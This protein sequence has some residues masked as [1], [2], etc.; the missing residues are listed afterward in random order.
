[1]E[2]DM[3]VKIMAEVWEHSQAKGSE[4]L[5]L[6]ALSHYADSV[7]AECWPSVRR[8]ALMIRMSERN[9]Q[10]LLRKL[11]KDGHIAITLRGST[12]KTNLYRILFPWCK[13]CTMHKCS[14]ATGCTLDGARTLAP[15][16]KS[17]PKP[18][19]RE[20]LRVR[21]EKIAEKAKSNEFLIYLG[22][23]PGGVFSPSSHNGHQ[24]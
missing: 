20:N 21:E 5:L 7:R 12:R 8:L 9:T 23:T 16:P 18:E 10:Y 22:A 14:G 3:S 11:A 15:D 4:L 6:L 17:E 24:E 13:L 2:G 1:M 19:E